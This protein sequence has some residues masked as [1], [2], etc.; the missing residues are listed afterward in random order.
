MKF[1][2]KDLIFQTVISVVVV[3]VNSFLNLTLS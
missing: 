2:Y 1:N 3:N